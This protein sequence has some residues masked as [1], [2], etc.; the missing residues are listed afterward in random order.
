MAVSQGEMQSGL[1]DNPLDP[2]DIKGVEEYPFAVKKPPTMTKVLPFPALAFVH[3]PYQTLCVVVNDVFAENPRPNCLLESRA[4]INVL[5]MPDHTREEG[6]RKCWEEVEGGTHTRY[7]T[8]P[9]WT[10]LR[11][12]FSI[13][14]EYM[15]GGSCGEW[16]S[17]CHS[18]RLQP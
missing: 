5:Q 7:V 8:P 16:T 13:R 10:T 15:R 3:K 11:P 17:V 18:N 6:A 14:R 9:D 4:Q 12:G 2:G 1:P